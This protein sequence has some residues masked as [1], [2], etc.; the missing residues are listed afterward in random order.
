MIRS[1]TTVAAVAVTLL[2]AALGACSSGAAPAAGGSTVT[3]ASGY[4]PATTD[5]DP[6]DASSQ[7]LAPVITTSIAGT[8]FGYNG[9]D[10]PDPNNATTLV[11]PRPELATSATLSPDGLTWTVQLRGDAQSEA[12]NPLTSDDVV[13]TIQRAF[14][15]QAIAANLLTK[16]VPLDPAK[17]VEA[18]GP[19]T[20]VFHLTRPSSVLEKVFAQPWLGILDKKAVTAAAGPADP[21]GYKWLTAHSATFGAYEVTTSELPQKIVLSA[22]PHYWRGAAP[23][24]RATIVTIADDSTRLQAALSGQVDLATG[25]A[26]TDL[27]AVTGSATVVPYTQPNALQVKLLTF[28]LKNPEVADPNVRRALSLS[29]DRQTI[30]D[31]VY[32]GLSSP[33]TGCMPT[34]LDERTSPLDVPAAGDIAQ[35]RALIAA[36]PGPHQVTIGYLPDAGNTFAQILQA[37]FQAVGVQATLKPYTSFTTWNADF[38]NGVFSVGINGFAPFVNDAAYLL[39]NL[40]TTTAPSNGTGWSNAQFDTAAAAAL[41]SDGAAK[42]TDVDTAC[43]VMQQASPIVP[44]VVTAQL[45]AANKKLTRVASSQYGVLLSNMKIG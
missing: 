38:R 2:T 41:S 20:V 21:W 45:A 11:D 32:E 6:R 13:W 19:A 23:I 36:S 14:N 43:R 8:L 34:L 17:P 26:S 44:V 37:G 31:K 16:T 33:V 1:R 15:S 18:T 4:M 3:I 12:G 10:A 28:S 24:S 35:A 7:Q 40:A 42:T 9:Q 39:V 30:S 22:N 25:L 29:I 27:K 5:L